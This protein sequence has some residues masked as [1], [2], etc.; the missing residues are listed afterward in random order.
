MTT[1]ETHVHMAAEFRVFS[2]RGQ[3]E[4][5][6]L[7]VTAENGEVFRFGVHV[8]DLAGLAEQLRRDALLLKG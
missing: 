5:A 1:P 6:A 7:Q 2:V 3:P 4:W 8:S